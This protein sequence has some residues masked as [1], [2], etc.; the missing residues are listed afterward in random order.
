LLYHIAVHVLPMVSCHTLLFVIDILMIL[1]FC[2]FYYA[3]CLCQSLS[4][5]VDR[6]HGCSPI[7]SK[8]KTKWKPIKS[9]ENILAVSK[10][11]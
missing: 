7:T 3:S 5:Y 11:H 1:S 4:I 2:G 6:E 10:N 8:D 9:P